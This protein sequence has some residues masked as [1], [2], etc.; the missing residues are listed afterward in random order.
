MSFRGPLQGAISS[1]PSPAVQDAPVPSRHTG[2]CSGLQNN[3]VPSSDHWVPFFCP[4]LSCLAKTVHAP[5]RKPTQ[6]DYNGGI[7][8]RSAHLGHVSDSGLFNLSAAQAGLAKSPRSMRGNPRAC[9]LRRVPIALIDLSQQ[10]LC[11]WGLDL[12]NTI[13]G[14]QSIFLKAPLVPSQTLVDT[15]LRRT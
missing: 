14:C 9:P 7:S 2:T 15:P 1:P 3:P 11:P 13:K 8:G 12:K 5:A 10:N 4:R 6:S